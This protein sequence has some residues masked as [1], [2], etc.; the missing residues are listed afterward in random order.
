MTSPAPSLLNTAGRQGAAR[1]LPEGAAFVISRSGS[2]IPPGDIVSIIF[3]SA[4]VILSGV[5]EGASGGAA[6]A[7]SS[8]AFP[9]EQPTNSVVADS[10]TRQQVTFFMSRSFVR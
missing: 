9:W 7:G 1:S 5:D 4:A 6:I 3:D 8:K 2:A 10:K